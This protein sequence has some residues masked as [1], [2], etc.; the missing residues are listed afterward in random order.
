MGFHSKLIVESL[1]TRWKLKKSFKFYYSDCLIRIDIEVPK[2][3]ITDFASTPRIL[4]SLL[5]PTGVYNKATVLHD[6]LYDINCT[7]SLT[8]KEADKFFLQALEVLEVP[9]L[10]R[11]LMWVGVRIGGAKSF[12]K[13]RVVIS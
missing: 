6:Y 3:F 7:T 2:G 13:A 8:R 1:G 11:Y 4:Y 5:P 9:K 12:R 10:I